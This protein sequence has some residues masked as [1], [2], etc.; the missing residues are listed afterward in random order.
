MHNWVIYN[1]RAKTC[2]MSPSAIPSKGAIA[3]S[4]FRMVN[5]TG[6]NMINCTH[7]A[8]KLRRAI[9]Q[10]RRCEWVTDQGNEGVTD[11]GAERILNECTESI[12]DF[13]NLF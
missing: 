8:G 12:S 6:A 11:S 9:L 13:P 4:P 3:C 2:V 10:K 1:R 5:L 7:H